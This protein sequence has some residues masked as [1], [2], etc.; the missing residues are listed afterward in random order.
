MLGRCCLDSYH[1]SVKR[2]QRA[3]TRAQ[4]SRL[5]S[6][7]LLPLF[8]LVSLFLPRAHS[9]IFL[10][11]QSE[12][13]RSSYFILLLILFTFLVMLL[14]LRDRVP[15]GCCKR[16]SVSSDDPL[17]AVTN[18][19]K[20]GV[21]A[22]FEGQDDAATGFDAW[23]KQNDDADA[24]E[25]AA[26][27]GVELVKWDGVVEVAEPV[28][29]QQQQHVQSEPLQHPVEVDQVISVVADSASS[30][31]AVAVA[32]A[33][34]PAAAAPAAEDELASPSRL[35]TPEHMFASPRFEPIIRRAQ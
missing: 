29:S 15:A 1:W 9:T 26:N 5:M 32:P 20:T 22:T 8:S 2:K 18:G 24:T 16:H 11:V 25:A 14:L 23:M 28:Q 17:A 30:S 4:V 12:G 7:T 21:V 34:A 31:A 3:N 33:P 27:N 13:S 19:T 6:L 35:V 10:A